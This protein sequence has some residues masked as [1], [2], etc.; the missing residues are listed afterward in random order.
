MGADRLI[1]AT[2][3]T[4]SRSLDNQNMPLE[5]VQTIN[6]R[7]KVLLIALAPGGGS[8]EHAYYQARALTKAGA[9][10]FFVIP[11]SFLEHR[12]LGVPAVR[13]LPDPVV[14]GRFKAWRRFKQIWY[15]CWSQWRAAF[16]VWMR[17]PDLVL[18]DSFFEYLAPI[19]VWP[20][21]LLARF[22][23][24]RY[25]ANLQDPIRNFQVGLRW[26]HVLSV[27]LA[28]LPL[29]FVLVHHELVN[30]A[31]VPMH[32][33]TIRVPVGVYEI[34]DANREGENL[35]GSWGV[36]PQQ[37]VYLAFGYIRDNKNLHLII[38]ALGAHPDAV[39]VM[40]G[41]VSAQKERGFAY[42]RNLAASKGVID[43]CV[44]YEGFVSDE[45]VGS[46]FRSADFIV[47]TYSAEFHSQS[48]VLNVAA[49]CRKP[50]LVSAGTGPLV[51]VVERFGLGVVVKPDSLP[52]VVEGMR[53]LAAM[54]PNPKWDE[55][56]AFASWDANA[57]AILD[58]AGMN[59][60]KEKK[61]D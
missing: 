51:D 23:G 28:Y 29:D 3:S 42:Y 36:K 6:P 46:W 14:A 32:V 4:M 26:W 30:P 48:G 12:D 54:P 47:L 50:V 20:H 56:S 1:F 60:A 27:R 19:W 15:Y 59:I 44:F 40:A 8:A 24:I 18:I 22:G 10:V 9:E 33:K 45:D 55:Y 25:A 31:T 21:W 7:P 43:R 34:R 35:R 53:R 13:V 38:E 17:H 58:A 49:Q 16:E 57:L 2:I 11:P 61:N 52:E 39:F 5:V 41:S 37:R